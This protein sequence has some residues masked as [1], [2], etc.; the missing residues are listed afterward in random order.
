MGKIKIEHLCDSAI[1][2]IAL[3]ALFFSVWQ[4][5]L[6]HKYNK[7]SVKPYLDSHLI[8]VDSTLEVFFSNE[9]F[10][11]AIIKKITFT[12][13]GKNYDS[14]REL[15]GDINEISNTLGSF[16]YNENAII[17][18]G[19]KKLLVYLKTEN[20]GESRFKLNT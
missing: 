18:A 19:D 12:H 9:G 11:P 3:S 7:L 13:N 2:M 14:I 4:V 6:G 8:Q 20:Q 16:N 10:G 15:L 5:S 17:A 1:I